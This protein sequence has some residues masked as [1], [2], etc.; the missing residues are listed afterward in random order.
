M[1][2]TWLF[3]RPGKNTARYS[4]KPAATAASAPARMIQYATQA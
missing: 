3:E 2:T 1:K 4:A